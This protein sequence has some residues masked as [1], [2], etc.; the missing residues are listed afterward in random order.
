MSLRPAIGL[1]LCLSLCGPLGGRP[2][3]G[4]PHEWCLPMSR[5]WGQESAPA[6]QDLTLPSVAQGEQTLRSQWGRRATI[7]VF[8]S[9][10]CPISNGYLPTLSRLFQERG[11]EGVVVLGLHS[12]RSQTLQAI[13]RHARDFAIPFP[14]FRD[15]SGEVARAVKAVTCPEVILFDGPGAIVYRGRIDDR[16]VRRGG[17]ARG[18]GRPDLELALNSLLAGEEIAVPETKVIGCP[19]D[20]GEPPPAVAGDRAGIP[21]YSQDIAPLLQVHC[22]E[23]HRQGGIGPF[24]L[25]DYEAARRW[26]DDIASFTA[27]RVMPPWKATPGF[28]DLAGSR[29]LPQTAIDTIAAW[30]RGGTP[31]GNPSDLPPPREFAVDWKLGREPDLVLDAPEYT[32]AAE[33]PD[34]YRCFVLPTALGEDQYVTALEVRPGNPRVVHHVLTFLDVQGRARELDRRQAGPGYATSAGFPGFL[35]TGNLGGW[36][37]GMQVRELPEGIVRLLPSQA[38]VVVQVHYHRSGRSE[39]DRTQIGL[40]FART[41]PQ[42]A[43]Q[44]V[45]VLPWSGPLGEFEIP[46]GSARHEVRTSFILPQDMEA[47]AITPHMHLLGHDIE[48]TATRPDG[49]RVDLIQIRDWDF[50]WQET[51]QFQSPISLPRKTRIEVLAHFDNSEDNPANPFRPVQ[52]VRWGESTDEEMC[53]AFVEMVPA[54]PTP[55][56]LKAPSRADRIQFFL[57]SQWLD[58]SRPPQEK[59]R[60][61]Q[62]LTARLKQLEESGGLLPEPQQSPVPS[63]Q[64]K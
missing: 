31:Q 3:G 4:G 13:T 43:V 12:N 24:A 18:K 60:L 61:I 47:V 59:L 15:P 11:D 32:L 8:L 52:T 2:D 56:P 9:T 34:E 36:A 6:W 33:G 10:E 30:V 42:R 62:R 64:P 29:H 26:A 21:T 23:C 7:L 63:Q 53:I 20:F 48:V 54:R 40:Y 17:P 46:A 41:P 39:T 1:S 38:D 5:A 55:G 28:G 44:N 37:P 58:D 19:I 25:N 14:L 45:P 57:Q 16:Y 50:N 27:S 35:P 51:Y 22:Q 49:T